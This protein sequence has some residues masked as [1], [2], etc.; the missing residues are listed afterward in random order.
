MAKNKL[1]EPVVEESKLH[2]SFLQLKDQPGAICSREML[3]NIYQDFVDPDGNFLEQFQTTGF[4]ARFFELYLFAYF[5]RSGF[6]L[7][8]DHD[9]PD[10]LISRNGRTVAVEAT[11]VNPPTSGVLKEKGRKIGDLDEAEL[12]HYVTEELPIRFGS[13]LFS[14]LKK[15]YWE[16]EHCKNIPLV[17][18]IQAF[19]DEDSL[20]VSDGALMGYLYGSKSTAQWNENAELVVSTN[21]VESHSVAEKVIPSGF[22]VQPESE[23][24]SAVIFT[25]SGTSGKFTRMGF[26][27]GFGNDQVSV[28]RRGECYTPLENAKDPSLF[29][30]NMECPPFVESWGQGLTVMHNPNALNPVPH[31]FFHYAIQSYL[32]DNGHVA[33]EYDS[34]VPWHPYVSKTL[35]MNFGSELKDFIKK[36][37]PMV[38]I[39]VSP[40]DKEHFDFF[41]PG[42]CVVPDS[43]EQGWFCDDTSSFFGTVLYFK[44]ENVWAAY[45]FARNEQFG[46]VCIYVSE[47]FTS[48][49][50][51][52]VHIQEQINSNLLFSPKRIFSA[53]SPEQNNASS[54]R[55]CKQ[56][57]A[58]LASR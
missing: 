3:E 22:F 25:N 10:F 23:Y 43:E 17:I 2:P 41:V 36:Y 4:D 6:Q 57:N 12:L 27:H 50:N 55:T 14:K 7:N 18:A 48:R 26:Q 16:H 52:R 13:P 29:A 42:E 58:K 32:A 15:K 37:P 39:G 53:Q 46:F 1:F 47:K 19:H 9:K 49:G 45:M 28:Y 11:T 54:L 24:I 34:L 51:A 40:I 20:S 5:S 21:E 56:S 31:D 35:T 44:K 30:Y 38:S 33:V 8:R